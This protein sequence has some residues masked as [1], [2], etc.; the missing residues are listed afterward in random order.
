MAKNDNNIEKS[1]TLEIYEDD[2]VLKR[3]FQAALPEKQ[4][5]MGYDLSNDATPEDIEITRAKNKWLRDGQP[6]D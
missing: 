4:D 2:K 6:V 5:R 3:M 1:Y